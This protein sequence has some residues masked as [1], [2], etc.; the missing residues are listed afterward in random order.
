M[1]CLL[2]LSLI[3]SQFL[4]GFLVPFDKFSQLNILLLLLM[5]MVTMMTMMM[6][7]MMMMTMRRRLFERETGFLSLYRLS[8][9]IYISG[10]LN[11]F[12]TLT[13]AVI[14]LHSD[15]FESLLTCFA[16][17]ITTG[18]RKSCIVKLI[19]CNIKYIACCSTKF[20]F[21]FSCL[22]NEWLKDNNDND[23]KKTWNKRH[24]IINEIKAG[25]RIM[26]KILTNGAR[27]EHV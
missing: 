2:F 18:G 14:A 21:C 1:S 10:N 11:W 16:V 27:K 20:L 4:A 13:K 19:F 12:I 17:T 22:L 5:M 25:K 8:W 3:L 24:K 23:N 15:T 26:L 6:I 7:M 9:Y